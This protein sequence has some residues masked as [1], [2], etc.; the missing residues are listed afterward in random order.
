MPT[1]RYNGK[2]TF[3]DSLRRLK[4]EPGE[5]VATRYILDDIP[6]FERID[7]LPEP[8]SDNTIDYTLAPGEEVEITKE[9]WEG[10]NS[11][12]AYKI[13]D[14][15][16]NNNSVAY[17]YIDQISN[18]TDNIIDNV[19]TVQIIYLNYRNIQKLILK[20]PETNSGNITIRVSIGMQ[21][22]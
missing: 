18:K 22:E 19:S 4:V 11:L 13:G 21:K 3:V 7:D 16:E 1:Y 9:Q 17:L 15:D 14:T 5:E 8:Y 12:V 10:L 2:G 6:G 20:A